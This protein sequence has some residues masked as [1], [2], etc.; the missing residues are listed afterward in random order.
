VDCIWLIPDQTVISESISQYIIKQ[1]VLKKVPVVGY[2]RFFYDSGAA[3][4]FVFD[5]KALGRQSADLIMDVLRQAESG[6]R[7]PVFDVWLNTSVLEKLDIKISEPL[8]AP[9]RVGP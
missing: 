8:S 7:A 4:A 6:T 5:Y 1:A 3:M 2:N 9:M